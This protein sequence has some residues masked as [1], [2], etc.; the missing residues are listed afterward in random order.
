ML[1]LESDVESQ[2]DGYV[3][4][5]GGRLWR[6]DLATRETT[7]V[8]IGPSSIVNADGI[9]LRGHT[10]WVVQNFTRQISELKLDGDWS[11]GKLVSVTPTPPS[12]TFTTAKIAN[13]RLLMVDSQFGLAPP[14][15][16]ADRVLATKL[17]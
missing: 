16:A 17:P 15:A 13:G 8:D 3:A 2:M 7:Q 4:T 10:L 1:D 6:I 12:R 11:A 14:F 9:V 5:P